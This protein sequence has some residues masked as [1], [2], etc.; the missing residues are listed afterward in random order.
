[1]PKL[2]VSSFILLLLSTSCY[3]Q[4]R[5]FAKTYT[6]DVLP[7]GSIDLEF[8]HTSRFGHSN[9]FYHAQ[10]QRMELEFGLG[11]NLQTSVYFNRYQTRL[12]T[13][14]EG[15][16]VTNEIGFSNEW[17]WKLSDP[18]VNKIGSALYAE[19]GLK[20]GDELELE[21]KLILDKNI[22]KSLIAF[23]AVLEYEKEFE[24]TGN[25]VETDNWALPVEIAL[26]Y[27][28]FAKPNLG[29]G[30]EINDHNNITK[31]NGYENSVIYAGPT[32]RFTH[33]KWFI[34]V[35]YQPQITNLHKTATSPFSKDLNEYERG[36]ARFI[37]GISL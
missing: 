5:Y 11:K 14:P 3:S 28:Y 12:S 8:W 15:T 33:N 10:D 16:S 36:E 21:T 37:V 30:F 20:G 29:I 24:W 2:I 7:S 26:A 32:C 35:N 18:A 6:S 27:Q 1:M 22:G 23:N 34:I 13:S 19:W 25:T 31:A 17:K 9:Q 4:D